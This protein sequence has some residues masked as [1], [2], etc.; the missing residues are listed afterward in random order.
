MIRVLVIDDHP[1]VRQGC[2][3]ILEDRGYAA[4][5]EAAGLGEG[6]RLYRREKPDVILLDLAMGRNAFA[7]LSFLRR[8]RLH[9]RRTPVLVFSMH[10]DPA[11]VA[12]AIALGANGYVLKD[13]LDTGLIA[14]VQAVREGKPYLSYELA[15][16]VA[17]LDGHGRGN[18]LHGLTARELQTLALIA[19]GKSYGAI[20]Q[21]LHVSYK[22]V[23]NTTSHIK[24]KLGAKS[25]P[26]LM[27]VAI[28]HLSAAGA[29]HRP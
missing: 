15:S 4:V 24:M 25:L 9:D 12:Q 28:R 29:R 18:P 5:L 27:R 20:A 16:E 1:I 11:I 21:D 19:E 6:F 13:T 2:R 14:A 23:A 3:R 10:A 26:E 7:G 8:L 22:T 17:F